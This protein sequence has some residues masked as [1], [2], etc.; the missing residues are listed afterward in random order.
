VE[1]EL[2]GLLVGGL[3]II[4]RYLNCDLQRDQRT[5]K[6]ANAV[7]DRFGDGDRIGAGTLGERQRDLRTAVEN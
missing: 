1:Q 3:T 4:A 5:V 6:L 2:V 7:Q